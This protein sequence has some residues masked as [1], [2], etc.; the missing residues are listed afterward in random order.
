M[1]QP[2]FPL[3]RDYT[4][5]TARWCF[6]VVVL[7][8]QSGDPDAANRNKHQ[9]YTTRRNLDILFQIVVSLKLLFQASNTTERASN[10]QTFPK[11]SMSPEVIFK[12][13]TGTTQVLISENGHWLC[14][15]SLAILMQNGWMPPLCGFFP[16]PDPNSDLVTC[17]SLLELSPPPPSVLSWTASHTAFIHWP[18]PPDSLSP[19]PKKQLYNIEYYLEG[20]DKRNWI[21]NSRD[22]REQRP[23]HMG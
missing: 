16:T 2:L 15:I 9:R 18:F 19:N 6:W 17:L 13:L 20:S 4:G 23:G 10:S 1:H 3:K 14:E 8:G 5:H 12:I 11:V 7:Q 22:S 21:N